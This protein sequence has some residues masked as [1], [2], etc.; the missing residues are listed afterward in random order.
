MKKLSYILLFFIGISFIGC[1]NNDP[2]KDLSN[3][4]QQVPNIYF[5]PIDP[6]AD[7]SSDL[8]CEIEYWTVGN[9]IKS[10]SLWDKI[11]L[12]EEYEISIK[13]VPYTYKNSF[14]TLQRDKE[15]Y[16]EYDFDFTDWTPDKNA[17]VFK[18][19]YFAWFRI[20]S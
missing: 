2:L 8:Q 4:G 18:T 19:K 20:L 12:T 17:Y 10:Q 1:E 13:D 11:Y 15:M 5:I 7:A 9:E 3:L 6:I 14:D 16:K